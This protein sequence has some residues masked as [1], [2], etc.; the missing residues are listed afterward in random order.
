M[1]KEFRSLLEE[2]R[3]KLITWRELAKAVA[4]H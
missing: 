3:V 1:N 4:T 2:Q